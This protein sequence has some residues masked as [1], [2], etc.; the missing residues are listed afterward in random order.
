[1]DGCSRVMAHV[2]V[3]HIGEVKTLK[4]HCPGNRNAC[5]LCSKLIIMLLQ[6]CVIGIL[7]I[8]KTVCSTVKEVCLAQIWYTDK[9]CDAILDAYEKHFH[10]IDSELVLVSGPYIGPGTM[11]KT[12][13]CPFC[14]K[15][16]ASKKGM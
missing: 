15:W 12:N 5:N 13:K 10:A 4:V 3:V 8:Q 6:I 9:F 16:F 7:K 11:N 2:S 1:M 14:S